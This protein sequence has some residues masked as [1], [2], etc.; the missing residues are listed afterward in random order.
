MSEKISKIVDGQGVLDSNGDPLEHENFEK[1]V[2]FCEEDDESMVQNFQMSLEEVIYL[3]DNL[4]K[5]QKRSLEARTRSK[6]TCF[7]ECN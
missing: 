5:L 3:Q 7:T 4:L 6:I 2:R 1:S